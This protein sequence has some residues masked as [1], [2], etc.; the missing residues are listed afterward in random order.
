M[1]SSDHKRPFGKEFTINQPVRD[2]SQQGTSQLRDRKLTL[3]TIPG[4]WRRKAQRTASVIESFFHA[5]RGFWTAFQTER[6]LRIHMGVALA[7]A[8]AALATGVDASG[9]A[10]LVLAIGLVI[11]AE[12]INT[13]LER[14]VDIATNNEFHRIARDAKDTA[15]AAVLCAAIMAVLIGGF[16]FVPR[17]ITILHIH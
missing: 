13:A 15:A 17:L 1:L 12:L 5:F 14:L 9:W 16:V 3:I 6:N 4:S 11:T 7:V 10:L 2:K 8:L